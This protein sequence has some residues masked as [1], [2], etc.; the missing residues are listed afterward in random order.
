VLSHLDPAMTEPSKNP[1]PFYPRYIDS[2]HLA[3]WFLR[4]TIGLLALTTRLITSIVLAAVR[5][6][7]RR[8]RYLR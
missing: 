1:V 2:F 6:R 8:N 3:N 5:F 7:R 4:M